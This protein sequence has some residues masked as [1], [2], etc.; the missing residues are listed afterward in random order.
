MHRP[1]EQLNENTTILKSLVH[2]GDSLAVHC[3]FFRLWFNRTYV[4]KLQWHYSNVGVCCHALSREA[5]MCPYS[6]YGKRTKH[7]NTL[8]KQ[9]CLK[10]SN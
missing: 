5:S 2:H 4:G 3:L 7:Q 6:D 8:R 9:N 1:V 10:Q